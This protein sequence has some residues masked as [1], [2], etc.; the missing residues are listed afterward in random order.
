LPEDIKKENLFLMPTSGAALYT[1][2][3][4]KKTWDKVFE[5]LISE[6]EAEIII[7]ELKVVLQ[8]QSIETPKVLYGEQFENRGT[9]IT[10][11]ALGQQAP[12]NEKKIC[13]FSSFISVLPDYLREYMKNNNLLKIFI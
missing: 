12:I 4:S 6:K 10:F 2:N 13:N 3:D 1:Y 5:N 7:R 11:S 8:E 9:Q